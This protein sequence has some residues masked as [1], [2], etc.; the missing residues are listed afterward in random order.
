MPLIEVDEAVRTEALSAMAPDLD[1]LLI[2]KDVDSNMRGTLAHLGFL[3]MTLFAN[4]SSS[5]EAMRAELK[6]DLGIQN[7]D[8]IAVRLQL[9]AVIE[10]WKRCAR[11]VTSEGRNGSRGQSQRKSS[12]ATTRRGGYFKRCSRGQVR[13]SGRLGLTQQRLCGLEVCTV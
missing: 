1:A 10:A 6:Q 4:F 13:R 3:N 7:T 11:K 5:E 12:R 8:P 9:S 2:D